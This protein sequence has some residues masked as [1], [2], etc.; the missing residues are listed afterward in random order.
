LAE[1]RIALGDQLLSQGVRSGRDL[2]FYSLEEIW[3]TGKGPYQFCAFAQNILDRRLDVQNVIPSGTFS[4]YLRDELR[5]EDSKTEVSEGVGK[6][7]AEVER[8]RGNPRY[9]EWLTHVDRLSKED[10]LDALRELYASRIL[11]VRDE[12]K[13]QLTLELTPLS[14]EELDERDSSQVHAAAEIFMHDEAKIPYYYGI[15]RLCTL[16]TSNVEELLALAAALYD[17]IQAKQVLR[18]AELQLSPQEQ[19]KLIRDVAKHKRMFIPKNHTEGTRAQRLLDSIGSY[20]RARTFLPSAPYAPGVTGVRLSFTELDKFNEREIA[21]TPQ[22]QLLKRVLS[23][24]VAENLLMTRSS[25]ASTSREAGTIFYLNRTLCANYGLPLQM[26]GWQDV[27]MEDLLEW[28][29]KG[30]G[31]TKRQRLEIEQ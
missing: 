25:G 12:T 20:C 13:K 22:R 16:A 7:T 14:P 1:R 6:F 17:G 30:G 9:S 23:E 27:D 15:D 4:Q 31:P 2:R 24:C 29:E 21:M 18:K 5:V 10:S 8:L 28:M 26:G 11:V 19:E 3:S